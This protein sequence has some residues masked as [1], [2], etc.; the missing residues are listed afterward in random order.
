MPGSASLE[1][2]HVATGAAR[3]SPEGLLR[4]WK[5]QMRQGV[6]ASRGHEPLAARNFYLQ[7]L[8]LAQ[9]L[10]DEP[11]CAVLD[12][13]DRLAAFVVSHLNLAE[14][15]ADGGDAAG[16]RHQ[17]C[18]AH[19]RLMDLLREP[20]TACALQRA[21]CRHSRETHAAL[22]VHLSEHGEHPEI[23]DTLREACLPFPLQ[24]RYAH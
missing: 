4:E 5:A 24:G 23:T 16:A 14:S 12:E 10:L 2:A 11:A 6:E 7:A 21:A 19:R 17:L 18:S 1:Q 8:D 20:G 9:A 3:S 15:L 13:D 22:I